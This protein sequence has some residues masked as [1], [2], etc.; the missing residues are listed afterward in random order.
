[1]TIDPNIKGKARKNLEET[2]GE[3]SSRFEGRQRFF[4]DKTQKNTIYKCS[5][6]DLNLY[7]SKD[8]IKKL[9]GQA[10]DK[11]KIFTILTSDKEP[12][13]R[14]YKELLHLTTQ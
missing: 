1:M 2:I 6:I 5:F 12:T 11:E 13:S 9:K 7:C 8:T 3:N 4:L 10:T 14:I